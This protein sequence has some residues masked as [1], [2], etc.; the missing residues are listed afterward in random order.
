MSRTTTFVSATQLRAQ[1]PASDIATPGSAS[2]T[3]FSPA[4][5]G[6]TSNAALLTITPPAVLTVN[7]TAA[8]PGAPITVTLESGAGNSW[9]WLA[10]A[11]AGAPV[12]TFLQWTYVGTGVTT[13]TWTVTAPAASA[14]YEFRY[15]L[16]GSYT[17]N[18]RSPS[19]TIAP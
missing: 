14:S 7:T 3:V 16:N 6:G 19:V 13:R 17:I 8:V 18:T 5:G 1:V 11:Q 10:F 15:F 9:D 12:T 4:P 2:V